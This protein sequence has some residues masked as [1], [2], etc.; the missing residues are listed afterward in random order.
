MLRKFHL[1]IFCPKCNELGGLPLNKMTKVF[2]CRNCEIFFHVDRSGHVK[3]G[4][5]EK[6][7]DAEAFAPPKGLE[8]SPIF[9]KI[10]AFWRSLGQPVQ[11]GIPVVALVIAG[12][13][14]LNSQ[15]SAPTDHSIPA[16]LGERTKYFAT[17]FG[18][19]VKPEEMKPLVAP[20]TYDEF[21]QFWYG[22]DPG[23]RARQ[24]LKRA[25]AKVLF[26]SKDQ[27]KAA[28]IAL[29]FRGPNPNEAADPKAKKMVKKVDEEETPESIML[30]WSLG[31]NGKWYL[32]GKQCLDVRNG[33]DVK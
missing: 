30:R 26:E 25:S 15:A 29:I 4:K 16:P 9:K 3:A 18:A 20:K 11:I 19:N 5:P 10:F 7:Q 12:V 8:E 33:K 24:P 22:M 1:P 27:K 6:A 23:V 14:Y 32:D 2:R 17:Q 13:V 31:A 28:S 21:R